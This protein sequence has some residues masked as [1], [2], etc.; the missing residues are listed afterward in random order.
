VNRVR[1]RKLLQL[2]SPSYFQQSLRSLWNGEGRPVPVDALG[3]HRMI[4]RDGSFH[5]SKAYRERSAEVVREE[6]R[7][8]TR[9]AGAFAIQNFKAPDPALQKDLEAFLRSLLA[10]GA[11]VDV[12]LP[13]Y[14]PEAWRDLARNVPAAAEAEAWI[15][16]LCSDLSIPVA[17]SYAPEGREAGFYDPSHAREEVIR[18]LVARLPN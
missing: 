18:A 3:P 14:H 11:R 9:S 10:D 17:G 7:G 16:G 8:F 5:G 15:R 6:A 2:A 1:V 12:V 4:L 13:P